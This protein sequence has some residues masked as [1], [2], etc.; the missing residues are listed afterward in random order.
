MVRRRSTPPRRR[1]KPGAGWG[2]ARYC[3]RLSALPAWP[4]PGYHLL[5]R[6]CTSSLPL[7]SGVVGI[8]DAVPTKHWRMIRGRFTRLASCRQKAAFGTGKY[9]TG[10][11]AGQ[12]L[13]TG[14]FADQPVRLTG[15]DCLSMKRIPWDWGLVIAHSYQIC[16][17]TPLSSPQTRRERRGNTRFSLSSARLT[18]GF[19]PAPLGQF[20]P[21]LLRYLPPRSHSASRRG[22]WSGPGRRSARPPPRGPGS[23]TRWS[24]AGRWDRT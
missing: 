20:S 8:G 17:Q 14:H 23:G 13:G 4:R 7:A 15:A 2:H 10:R 5:D 22:S 19:L 3:L 24:S 6:Q 18:L 21:A 1:E 11:R 16:V 9:S 12:L